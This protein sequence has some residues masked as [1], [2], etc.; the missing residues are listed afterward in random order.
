MM[1]LLRSL[2]QE[3]LVVKEEADDDKEELVEEPLA[4]AFKFLGCPLSLDVI[5]IDL[6]NCYHSEE[7]IQEE[8]STR[9]T[10][11]KGQC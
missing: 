3:V 5:P 4:L 2:L 6:L 11:L 8:T 10:L 1:V 7:D 9:T